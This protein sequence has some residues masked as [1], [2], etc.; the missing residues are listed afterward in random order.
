MRQEKSGVG[1]CDGGL[2]SRT[3]SGPKRERE[4]CG[5]CASVFRRVRLRPL[6]P[7]L[8]YPAA[9]RFGSWRR[10]SRHWY[11]WRPRSVRASAPSFARSP[12]AQCQCLRSPFGQ[13]GARALAH[14][15]LHFC[16][17]A[18]ARRGSQMLSE[19]RS[20]IGWRSSVVLM[21]VVKYAK[22]VG[23]IIGPEGHI[24]RWTAPRKKFNERVLKI[25]ASTKSLVERLCDVNI[26][27]LS[28]LGYIGSIS[29]PEKATLKAEAHAPQCTT[30]GPY[31][32]IPTSLLG[33]GSVCRLGLDLVGIH[34]IS[35]AARYRTTA[36]SNMLSQELEKIQAVRAYDSAPIL[37][38]SSNWEKEFLAPSV[39][40][41]T[42]EAF[43]MVCC[44]DRN[45]KRDDSPQ[46]KKQKA[47]TTLLRDALYWQD[48]A[49]PI[50]LRA[51]KVL[52]LVIRFRIMEILPHMKLAS[53]ASRP[54]LTVGFL[55]ILSNRLCTA[56]R[57]HIEGEEQ[58]CRVG[59]PDE[60]DSLP[61]YNQ[62]LLLYNLL[63]SIWE[64]AA[65]LPRR[66]HLLHD[67]IT[68]VYLRS[69]QH[70]IVVMGFIDS[71]V[72]AHHQHRRSIEN[73]GNFGD[74]MIGRIRFMTAITPAYAHAYQVTCLTTHM[75]A[76]PRLNF[77]LP[78]PKDIRISP[79]FVPQRAMT[80]KDGPSILTGV[81]ALLMVKP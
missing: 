80:S 21:K 37:A 69:L 55:R 45:G 35:L 24:H 25:N 58:T 54:G 73:S 44:L 38:L 67:L 28:V 14:A 17:S 7:S 19:G 6:F 2:A 76:V 61:H 68:Q 32:A 40:R 57:F 46:D 30:A 12:C 1:R 5:L 77:R 70:G 27:A 50:S 60:P 13:G 56:Q 29:A 81:L 47:A 49:G 48:F 65:A 74:C 20:A 36:C 59:C 31:N 62:C 22:Y 39:A 51:S 75:H 64:H 53:G 71:F 8:P 33:V 72:Y 66:G 52:G 42:A 16:R 78:K 11:R 3:T 43:N 79:T 34:S 26:C 41:S 15:L 10:S 63:N 4:G 18:P 9:I 23:T